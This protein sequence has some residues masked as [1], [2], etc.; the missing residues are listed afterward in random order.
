M[1]P[2]LPLVSIVIPSYNV[3]QYVGAAID[4]VVRQSYPRIEIIVV[5]DG[6]TDGTSEALAPWLEHVT[7]LRQDRQGIGAARNAGLARAS[8]ELLGLLDADDLFVE[9][10]IERQVQV[11]VDRADVDMV[12]GHVE[13]FHSADP[14]S[15]PDVRPRLRPGR[16]PGYMAQTMLVRR[17]AFDRVGPFDRWHVGEF[18]DWY[19]RAT[20]AGLTAHMLPEVVTLRRLHG[21]NTGILH[22]HD[23]RDFARVLKA[24]LDRRRAGGLDLG[25]PGA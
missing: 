14:R 10:K 4:S 24:A 21:T 11:L 5:D 2:S 17:S 6:S 20:E 25:G 23:R 22:R 1:T 13:E 19:L 15:V 7:C 8:G 12:F 16:H 18:V 3:A 9:D